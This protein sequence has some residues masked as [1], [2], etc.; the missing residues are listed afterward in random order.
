MSSEWILKACL[1]RSLRLALS[2]SP[3]FDSDVGYSFRSS[4]TAMVAGALAFLCVFCA[5][6]AGWVA[7]HNPFDLTTLVLSDARL[8]PAWE[9]EGSRK[10]LLGWTP[11]TYDAH[12][13][14]NA[15]MACVDDK[16]AGQ[17]NLGAYCNPE[18]DKLTRAI[19]SETDKPK[20]NKMIV[21]AFKAHADDVGHLPLHQQSLAWGVS[22]K[23]ELVQLADNFMPFKWI[24]IKK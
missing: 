15:L 14:L 3:W 5:A 16:G 1:I 17:F 4:P 6:F 8:P 11:G 9:A 2:V 20:R 24:T 19:Q 10:Y 18:V 21:D 23:V 22:K 7:P 12:N 13:A